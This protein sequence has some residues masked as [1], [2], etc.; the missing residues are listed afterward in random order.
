MKDLQAILAIFL[1]TS[2]WVVVLV[3]PG[4]KSVPTGETFA[5]AC[6]FGGTYSFAIKTKKPEFGIVTCRDQRIDHEYMISPYN[7]PLWDGLVPGKSVNCSFQVVSYTKMFGLI[8]DQK[9]EPVHPCRLT[10]AGW[11][12][13]QKNFVKH[14]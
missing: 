1:M 7:N 6:V 13:Y 5:V 10:G 3:N 2:L 11:R 8:H 4:S 9:V 12:L 14:S